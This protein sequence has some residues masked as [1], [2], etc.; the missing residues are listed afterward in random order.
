MKG[1]FV[2]GFALFLLTG[3]ASFEEA[4][5]LDREFGK[6]QMESWNKMIAY[7]DYRYADQEPEGMAGIHGE[8]AMDIYHRSFDKEPTHTEVFQLG[9]IGQ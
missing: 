5:Y 1:L 2:A 3:C 8:A 4:Y 6:A 7:P 9:I